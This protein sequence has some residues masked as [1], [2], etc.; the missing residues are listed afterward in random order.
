VQ[1]L[2]QLWDS[3]PFESKKHHE[4]KTSVAKEL[5]QPTESLLQP[6]DPLLKGDPK[7]FDI[8]IV[9][10][11]LLRQAICNANGIQTLKTVVPKDYELFFPVSSQTMRFP[12]EDPIKALQA[13]LIAE[14]N[15]CKF[16]SIRIS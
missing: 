15:V 10:E 6:S 5:Q 16:A 8:K 3:A 14:L 12:A 13:G 9:K 7:C 11:R 4:N 1:K 2:R